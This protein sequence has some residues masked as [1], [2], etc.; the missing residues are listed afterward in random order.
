MHTTATKERFFSTGLMLAIAGAILFSGKSIFIK[1]AYEAG[2]QTETVLFYRMVLSLPFFLYA[3]IKSVKERAI[4]RIPKTHIGMLLFC[5]FFGYYLASWL[6]F[7]SLHFISIQLE[8]IIL[9]SYPALVV[10]GTAIISRR[11]PSLRIALAACLT[12]IGVCVIFAF[13]WSSPNSEGQTH[14]TVMLGA[15]LVSLSALFFAANILVSKNLIQ[16]YGSRF[17]TGATMIISTVAMTVHASTAS[18]VKQ[19]ISLMLPPFG[20]FT[21]LLLLAAIGTVIPAFMLSEAV[22]RIGPERTSISG[23]SGPIATSIIAVS[24]LGEAF[25]LSHALSLIL[26]T[27][28]IILIIRHPRKAR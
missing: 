12:Y 4:K 26:C 2:L 11:M 3:A 23:T 13:E 25:T 22:A 19:D 5:G 10:L 6:S 18:I 1:Y 28:G 14:D 15:A 8:R 17:F 7:Y 16:Q 9:F 24:F 27:T 21:I 20:S